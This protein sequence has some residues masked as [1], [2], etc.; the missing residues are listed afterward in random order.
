MLTRTCATPSLL[1]ATA[2]A[3]HAGGQTSED[4][5]ELQMPKLTA[6][7]SVLLGVIALLSLGAAVFGALGRW[8]L[9]FVFLSLLLG[10]G[11]AL[12]LLTFSNARRFQVTST[13][14]SAAF[15]RTLDTKHREVLKATRAASARTDALIERTA[16]T[17]E[18]DLELVRFA[19][20]VI[21]QGASTTKAQLTQLDASLT[22][23]AADLRET[24]AAT[25]EFSQSVAS[26]L[27]DQ[28][29]VPHA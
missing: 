29:D 27:L 8:E 1:E 9:A 6:R 26:G 12:L 10:L 19:Q 15:R 17:T 5:T 16:L 14:A 22:Q 20:S 7:E 28:S 4:K 23:V 25:S 24:L 2:G 11:A 3:P 21:T 13:R 18:R